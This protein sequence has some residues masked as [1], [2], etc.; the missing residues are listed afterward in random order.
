MSA[1]GVVR[2]DE[3]QSWGQVG[4]GGFDFLKYEDML[5]VLIRIAS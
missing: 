3:C 1:T 4:G 2:A 5:C